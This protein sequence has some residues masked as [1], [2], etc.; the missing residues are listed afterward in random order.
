MRL[1]FRLQRQKVYPTL[2]KMDKR[3]KKTLFREPYRSYS[4]STRIEIQLSFHYLLEYV[5]LQKLFL[6]YED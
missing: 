6:K 1:S 5:N 2:G 3:I 4:S